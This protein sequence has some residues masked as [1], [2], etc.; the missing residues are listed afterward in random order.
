MVL[1]R[2]LVTALLLL[3]LAR[4]AQAAPVNDPTL[5][6]REY[7]TPHFVL[8]FPQRLSLFAQSVSA[9]AEHAW[10]TLV[11][12]YDLELDGKT[13][14]ILWD[15]GESSNGSA[16]SIRNTINLY[17]T[18]NEIGMRDYA[19]WAENVVTHEYSHIL[20]LWNARVM[21]RQVAGVSLAALGRRDKLA[22]GGGFWKGG[23]LLYLPAEGTPRWFAEGI[24]QYDAS[25]LG[26]DRYDSLRSMLLRSALLAEADISWASL[27]T[28]EGKSQIGAELVYNQGFAFTG[29]LADTY[30][31]DKLAELTRA[32]YAHQRLSFDTLI[33]R[34]YGVTAETL[35]GRWLTT[36]RQAAENL[37]TARATTDAAA[38]T[39]FELGRFTHA[40][41]ISIDGRWALRGSGDSE[42]DM[43]ELYV[44]S[45]AVTAVPEADNFK[46]VAEGVLGQPAWAPDGSLWYCKPRQRPMSG[47]APGALYRIR[48]HTDGT[49]E[50]RD[51]ILDP[52]R[53]TDLAFTSDGDLVAA[54]RSHNSRNLQLIAA[55][56]LA[57]AIEQAPVETVAA[58]ELTRFEPPRSAESP[59]FDPHSRQIFF[60]LVD[61][62]QSD[63][64]RVSLGGEITHQPRPESNERSPWPL[65]DGQ[66]LYS[67]NRDAGVYDLWHAGQRLTHSLGGFFEPFTATSSIWGLQYSH[68]QF[69]LRQVSTDAAH[70]TSA[71]TTAT[72]WEPWSDS[73]S[74]PATTTEIAEPSPARL[75]LGTPLIVPE[76]IWQ[77]EN[78][79]AGFDLVLGDDRGLW[80]AE[81]EFLAGRD[82]DLSAMAAY[83][84]WWI[85]VE[86]SYDLYRR[87]REFGVDAFLG[88]NT[89]SGL[90]FR[91]PTAYH[92]LQAETVVPLS[93]RSALFGGMGMA[94]YRYL[95]PL[96]R[97]DPANDEPY[98]N[99]SG[100]LQYG[101]SNVPP[102]SDMDVN[103]R[104][105]R[106]VALWLRPGHTWSNQIFP[107]YADYSYATVGASHREYLALGDKW[108]FE[109]GGES[110]VILGQRK[111]SFGLQD[112]NGFDELF[113]GGE[114]FS[115]RRGLFQNFQNFAGY[116]EFSVSGELSAT[117]TSA[118]RWTLMRES[119][120]LGPWLI[121][122]L[123][124]ELGNGIG[125][126]W[127]ARTKFGGHGSDMLGFAS[128]RN[129]VTEAGQIADPGLISETYLAL[130][131]GITVFGGY[132]WN[133][134]FKVARGWQDPAMFG[135]R[136]DTDSRG[137][138]VVA[139]GAR[140]ALPLRFYLGLGTDF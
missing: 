119:G 18:T 26:F 72:S 2:A 99:I 56:D 54:V 91:F 4:S 8:Y 68:E 108:S 19:P 126:A 34:T 86:L 39:T 125:R 129:L 60:T 63:L 136:L 13:T 137:S 132:P 43:A 115:V 58:R 12:A 1:V 73:S 103:P 88:T 127:S 81:L 66:V 51:R 101:W 114:Y 107:T 62:A 139:Q 87:S 100:Y 105:G 64:A 61:G 67:S 111:G 21:R 71:S 76:L 23:G 36:Q 49:V 133:S 95:S 17:G 7:E 15:A 42:Y 14:V 46:L 124:L 5:D 97:F 55:A 90:K 37:R 74:A 69:A 45:A 117:I 52:L 35:Y 104:G 10:G 50:R 116:E 75:R 65:P 130:R 134:Y 77:T 33:Q 40:P 9:A 57:S 140:P 16:M 6:W 93:R 138:A 120:R 48:F 27:S 89:G 44:S 78:F 22:Q 30:G 80:Q 79:E 25:R 96:M 31:P 85:P 94:W 24:A 109:I 83:D 32:A 41:A 3:G 112:V 82:L 20:T 98:Q 106:A 84:G 70:W 11:P 28:T 121:D 135:Y 122:G 38:A 53:C 131:A 59:V 128:A 29:W 123:Y 118:L 102:A 47:F 113:L 110:S 92:R